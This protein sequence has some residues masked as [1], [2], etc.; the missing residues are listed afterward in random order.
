MMYQRTTFMIVLVGNVEE[1]KEWPF[2][3]QLSKIRKVQCSS[4]VTGGP[5]HPVV[6]LLVV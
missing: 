6:T 4:K 1:S 5:L 2:I 3:D